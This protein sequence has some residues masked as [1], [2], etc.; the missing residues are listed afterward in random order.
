MIR[1][2]QARQKA[3]S[4]HNFGSQPTH[5]MIYGMMEEL[6]EMVHAKLKEEQGIRTNENHRA[7]FKDAIGDQII[8]MMGLCNNEGLD[9]QSIIEETCAEV[10]AR[11]WV[12]FPTNG[13]TE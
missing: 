9:L 12:K 4:A 5:Q 6:G 11:D 2:L 8:Y 7:N 3:W 1:H 10:F 13:M